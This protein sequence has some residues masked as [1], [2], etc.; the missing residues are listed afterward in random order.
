MNIPKR[1]ERIV[2]TQVISTSGKYQLFLCEHIVNGS[3]CYDVVALNVETK[4]V[5][6]RHYRSDPSDSL[7]KSEA[8]R[9]FDHYREQLT[10][11]ANP[12]EEDDAPPLIFIDP[13]QC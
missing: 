3:F 6:S 4:L 10:K 11:P 2:L 7:N 1:L 8:L 9:V 5:V 13:T 12:Q